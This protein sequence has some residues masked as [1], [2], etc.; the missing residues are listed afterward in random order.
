MILFLFFACEEPEC[1][2]LQ[3]EPTEQHNVPQM[4]S[5]GQDFDTGELEDT[6]YDTGGEQ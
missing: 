4:H 3:R 6:A 1:L 5:S 2:E